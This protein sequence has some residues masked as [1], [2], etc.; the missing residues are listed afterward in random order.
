MVT[1]GTVA[2]FLYPT[3]Y[4]LNQQWGLISGGQSSFGVYVGSTVH[5]VAQVVAA[6]QSVGAGAGGTAVITKMVRVMM[7]AP[8]LILLSMWLRATGA[9]QMAAGHQVSRSDPP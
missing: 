4:G 7:L 5:E 2:I 6:A 3:L 9:M 8:F 1:F